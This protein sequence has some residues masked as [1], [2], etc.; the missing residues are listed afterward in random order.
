MLTDC[1]GT[2]TIKHA[3]DLSGATYKGKGVKVQGTFDMYA[4][5]ITGNTSE[6]DTG[7]SSVPV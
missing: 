7:G 4:G 2:G 6:Y 5:T 3:K 1:Q